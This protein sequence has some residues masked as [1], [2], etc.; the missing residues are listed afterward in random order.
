MN[1]II[2]HTIVLAYFI[3]SFPVLGIG[4]SLVEITIPSSANSTATN[5]PVTIYTPPGKSIRGNVLL[6]PG[7]KFLRHRWLNETGIKAQADRLGF[8][9]ICPEMNITIYESRYFPETTLKWADTPGLKWIHEFLIPAMKSKG[10]FLPG[11]N[12]FVLGLS[13]GGRGAV[14]VTLD[15]PGLF[16]ASAA[17]SGDFDQTKMPLDNLMTAVYG[18]YRQ[19]PE[20]WLIDNPAQQAKNWNTPLY[21]AHGTKD[22]VVP[23][24]QT[25][26]FYTLLRDLHIALDIKLFMPE[27]SHDFIFWSSQTPGV[28]EFFDKYIN[29][30][31]VE[32]V[33]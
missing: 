15:N 28:M 18:S 24:S 19:F 10:I 23:P 21:L 4:G 14:L 33:K 12:N 16:N 32:K 8:R 31:K 26:L 13:T 9:L 6:L 5:I 29:K 7:W 1:Q 3:V 11:Q 17:L 27:A 30:S 20:R 2:F 25:K 22:V